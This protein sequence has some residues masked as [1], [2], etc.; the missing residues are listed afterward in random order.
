MRRRKTAKLAPDQNT[1]LNWGLPP[2]FGLFTTGF[3][4]QQLRPLA[5][6]GFQ[7]VAFNTGLLIGSD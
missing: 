2:G 6:N 1:G 5:P 7:P 4:V 3:G